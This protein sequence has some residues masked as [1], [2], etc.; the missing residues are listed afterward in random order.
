MIKEKLEKYFTLQWHVTAKC[1]QR[2]KHCYLFDKSYKKEIE[3]ELSYQEC[4]KVI[5]DFERT[6]KVWNIKGRISFSG[7]D[8]LLRKD[9]LKL[10]GYARK[11]N[12][13][14]VILGNPYH[15]NNKTAR[16]LKKLGISRYQISIDGMQ[17]KHDFFR[18][19]GSFKD[20]VRAL[21]CLKKHKIKTAVMF[22]LSK[23][24]A[25]ELIKVIRF[26]S[27]LGVDE[28]DFSRFVPVGENKDF[29]SIIKGKEYEKLL[30]S[31]AKEYEE[32][33]KQGVK[34]KFGSKE[35]LW[36][37]LYYGLGKLKKFPE[38][39]KT[40]F[41]GC[42]LG[43]RGLT[44]LAD[45]TVYACRRLP[46]KIGKVPEQSIRDIFLNSRVLKKLRNLN[47]YE[48]C[49]N[50]KLRQFCRGCPAVAYSLKNNQ[51]A[52]DSSCWKMLKN[53]SIERRKK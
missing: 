13:D 52:P 33:K 48:K 25:E 49:K 51:F 7:G 21:K 2:C 47:N 36:K 14:I 46:I 5:D 40:I 43:S 37:L 3:N 30:L 34:T 50:C 17:K 53:K 4:I 26:V 39:K 10:A 20:S 11:K 9:F 18:R 8:P 45:G 35:S 31:V 1:D 23:A 19:P 12:I 29:S 27:K 16:K 6:L 41:G 22:T 32:L 38:D 42:S 44:I 28:F 24:N 15:I